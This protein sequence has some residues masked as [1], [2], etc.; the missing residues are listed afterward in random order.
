MPRI[1]VGIG[2]GRTFY[3]GSFADAYNSRVLADGGTIESLSCVSGASALLQQASLLF[4]PSGYKAGVAYS[5]LPNN[6]NGDLTW[7]RNSTAYRTQS[8]GNIGS[9]AANV[10]RLSYM[11]GSCPA[12]LLEPQRTNGIRNSTMVG[13]SASPSTFPTNWSS[14]TGLAQTIVGVGVEN[15]LNYVDVNFNG[16]ATFGSVN[17]QLENSGIIAASNGQNWSYSAYLKYVN[18]TAP[19]TNVGFLVV[20]RASGTNVGA[21]SQTIFPTSVLNRYSYN[22]TTT[23][24][25]ITHVQPYIYVN[26]T[27][28]NSY[29]FTIRVAQPQME[30]GAYATTP[31][32]TTGSAS[33]TRLAD[34]FTRNNIYTNGLITSAGG[35]WYVE[36]RNNVAYTRDNANRI[37]IG[38]TS[39]LTTNALI[40]S[41][42]STSSRL[43]IW[44][45]ISGSPTALYTTTTDSVKIAIKWNGSTADVFVNGTKQVSASAFTTTLM[46]NLGTNGV[47]LPMF[48]QAMALYNTPLSDSD[49]VTLT[50]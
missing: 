24:S 30:Q 43:Q 48:I 47:G 28:G 15:G 21:L 36:L 8:D 37:G 46:E 9:V 26:V 33:V 22:I 23:A 49:C 35:T 14:G 41:L 45:N 25:T 3:A 11:Y 12:A 2:L 20:Q 34:S 44:K 16:I 17:F 6:G 50:T 5:A 10:P 42:A 31:I 13:A 32:F 40:L 39:A 1:G 19:P 4:I 27:V 18:Q 38:D 29:D 7:S